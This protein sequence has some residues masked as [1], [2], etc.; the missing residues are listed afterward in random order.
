G[1]R[2]LRAAARYGRHWGK[3]LAPWAEKGVAPRPHLFEVEFG[4]PASDGDAAHPPLVVRSGGVEVRLS[5]RS[6]RGDLAEPPDSSTGF[7]VIDYETGRAG[8]YTGA[9]L[10][11]F[12]R[13]QLT[14]YALAVEEVLLA[15]RP[16]RPLGLA[17]WLVS[18]GGPKVALPARNQVL[19]L[20]ET[21]RWREV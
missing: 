10:A 5:G 11:E 7:W 21:R 6:D 18:E 1:E 3:L 12:R 8:N 9:D 15:G 17:Y 13:L 16:A 20:D 14:I 4:L 19:W 2:L